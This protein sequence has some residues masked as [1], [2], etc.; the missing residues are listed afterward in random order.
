MNN[1]VASNGKNVSRSGTGLLVG[2]M[3]F[4]R[5]EVD[6]LREFFVAK[7]DEEL[8]RWRSPDYPDYSIYPASDNLIQVVDEWKRRF[9]Y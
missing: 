7:Q 6:A 8:G 3:I 2:N 4:Y 5:D 9:R 1:F